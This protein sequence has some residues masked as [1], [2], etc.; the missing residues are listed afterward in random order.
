MQ[1][2]QLN[3]T[4]GNPSPEDHQN[5][6]S[7]YNENQNENIGHDAFIS[8]IPGNGLNPNEVSV[9]SAKQVPKFLCFTPKTFTILVLIMLGCIP[10]AYFVMQRPTPKERP[11]YITF[12]ESLNDPF[13]TVFSRQWLPGTMETYIVNISTYMTCGNDSGSTPQDSSGSN[14]FY[15]T[16]LE[17]NS[18]DIYVN[19]LLN[20]IHEGVPLFDPNTLMTISP[21]AAAAQNLSIIWCWLK[22]TGKIASCS[23]PYYLDRSIY[24][25]MVNLLE[26]YSPVL[27]KKYYNNPS[28]VR[29]L[30]GTDAAS[31]IQEDRDY[32]LEADPYNDE[33][34]LSN[35][36]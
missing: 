32:T 15:I 1:V 17:A 33:V 14:Y 22:N 12:M 26:Q 10:V 31:N 2:D 35:E 20:P 21:A 4:N 25:L 5:L 18:T 28:R 8:S 3:V 34:S 36:Y 19:A 13:A 23:L 9:M 27:E 16:T 24:G 29:I 30:Q 7:R 6:V 11:N